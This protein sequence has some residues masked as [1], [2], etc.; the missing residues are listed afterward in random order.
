MSA[1]MRLKNRLF[2]KLFTRFPSLA[3][4]SVASYLPAGREGIPWSPVKKPLSECTVALVTTAGVHPRGGKP[5]DMKDPNGD[6]AFRTIRGPL[7]DLMITHD[8][9]DH[10][11]ADRD[12][13]I[14]FPLERLKEFTG[15]GIIGKVAES[16]YG[17]MGHILGPRLDTLINET[18]PEV[19]RRLEADRVDVVLLTPG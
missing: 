11:D 1:M 19:A 12:M 7:S 17:F 5:F 18:A 6:P 2:A 3:K 15:E 4:R 10:T 13:N 16:H 8:Y 9:Y 14:V